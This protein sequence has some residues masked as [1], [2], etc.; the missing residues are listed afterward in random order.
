M[1]TEGTGGREVTEERTELLSRKTDDI[2]MRK[3]PGDSGKKSQLSQRSC[4]KLGL[5]D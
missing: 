2:R 3:Q 5:V 4:S 1:E